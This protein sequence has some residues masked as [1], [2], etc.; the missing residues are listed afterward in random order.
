MANRFPISGIGGCKRFRGQDGAVGLPVRDCR[1]FD[2]EPA[3]E[4]DGQPCQENGFPRISEDRATV[5]SHLVKLP[6]L[7]G[8]RDLI[9]EYR[10][11]VDP[12]VIVAGSE[13]RMPP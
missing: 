5:Q 9:V 4:L 1:Y 7:I 12:A 11:L 10:E 8:A 6:D 13:V 2:N 3:G